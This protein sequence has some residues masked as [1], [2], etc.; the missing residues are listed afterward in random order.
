MMTTAENDIVAGDDL[1]WLREDVY[2]SVGLTGKGGHLFCFFGKRPSGNCPIR[3]GS[4]NG[5]RSAL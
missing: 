5:K 1:L 2:D 4:K 3:T